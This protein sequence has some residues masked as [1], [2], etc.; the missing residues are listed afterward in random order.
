MFIVFLIGIAAIL[1]YYFFGIASMVETKTDNESL[2]VNV[3]LP[4]TFIVFPMLT[5]MTTLISPIPLFWG[6]L[7][8]L[9]AV[10][11]LFFFDKSEYPSGMYDIFNVIW[12]PFFQLVL[13]AVVFSFI[14]FFINMWVLDRGDKQIERYRKRD[15]GI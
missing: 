1:S 2:M 10:F 11:E 6:G 15:S 4:V 9:L 12:D 14:M 3:M 5:F 13:A 7:G 8:A